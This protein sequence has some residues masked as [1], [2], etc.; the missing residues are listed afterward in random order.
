MQTICVEIAGQERYIDYKPYAP[1]GDNPQILDRAFEM[2][3][4]VGYDVSLRWVFYNLWQEGYYHGRNKVK[5]YDSFENTCKEARTRFYKGWRPWTLIDKT[6]GA[7]YEG[8]GSADPANWFENYKDNAR[9]EI[10]KHQTQDYYIEVWFEARAMTDQFRYYTDYATLRPMAGYSSVTFLW[11]TAVDLMEAYQRYGKPIKVLYFGDLDDH[12]KQIYES[13]R[14]RMQEWVSGVDY[15]MIRC[16]LTMEHV[17]KYDIPSKV[18]TKKGEKD[19]G[20]Q[21]EALSDRGAKEVITSNLSEFV[22][23]AQIREA[24]AVEKAATEKARSALQAVEIDFSA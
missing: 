12:G 1:R 15:E 22:G 17:E 7:F 21:W 20:Y 23:L 16:G 5:A 10:D 9:C 24:E 2:V 19:E 6:R 14:Q 3:N 13:A 4:S 11:E 18:K 8:F